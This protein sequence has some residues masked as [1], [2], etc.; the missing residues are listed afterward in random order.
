MWYPVNGFENLYEVDESGV[1]RNSRSLRVIPVK[2]GKVTLGKKGVVYTIPLSGIL[3]QSVNEA[4]AEQVRLAEEK[5]KTFVKM[6]LEIGNNFPW[7]ILNKDKITGDIGEHLVC[8]ELL[9]RG[10]RCG[11]NVMEGC[12]YDVVGDFGGGRIFKI[13]VKTRSRTNNDYYEFSADIKLLKSCDVMAYVA[14]D[15][16]IV[17]FELCDEISS[18]SRK[19][20]KDAFVM[21][22]GSSIDS[23]V[24]KL[25][26]RFERQMMIA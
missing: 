6:N 18:S 12:I 24:N 13:Q 19:M 5:N 14:L 15:E 22:G 17:V 23:V 3:L 20:K 21:L 1:V 2:S 11:M 9:S 25:Y 26:S 8:V 7:E 16:R 10:I 4:A